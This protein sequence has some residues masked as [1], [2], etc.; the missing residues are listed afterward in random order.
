MP[1]SAIEIASAFFFTWVLG[2]APAFIARLVSQGPVPR[3]RATWIAAT[4]CAVL[5]LVALILKEMAGEANPRISPAWILVFI[6]SRWIMVRGEKILTRQ[7][8]IVGLN[9]MIADPSTSVERR[10][11]AQ[12]RLGHFQFDESDDSDTPRT[13]R[14]TPFSVRVSPTVRRWIVSVI[15]GLVIADLVLA[16]SG[17]RLLVR[18][19]LVQPGENYE[20]GH[21]GDLGEYGKP[22]LACWYWTG[23]NLIP[24]ASWFGSGE[25]EKDECGLLHKHEPGE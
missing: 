16:V 12:E 6:V 25:S 14:V 15:G 3:R 5:A 4:T 24:E 17:Y 2:L 20:A 18:E 13:R 11:W 21:W 19:R 8:I 23:R 22:A 7:E 9:E 10:A 1:F